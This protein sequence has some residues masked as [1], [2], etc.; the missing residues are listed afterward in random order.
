MSKIVIAILHLILFSVISLSS[1]LANYT[2]QDAMLDLQKIN[3]KEDSI[4]II[5]KI[6]SLYDEEES[7]D[8]R[9]NIAYFLSLDPEFKTKR[10]QNYYLKV[11]LRGK[12]GLIDKERFRLLR[13]LADLEFKKGKLESA[14]N[15][16]NLALEIEGENKLDDYLNLQKFWVLVNLD[17]NDEALGSLGD[18]ILKEKTQM[19]EILVQDYA[20]VWSESL[21]KK[22][23]QNIK[24][25][26]SKE[27]WMKYRSSLLSGLFSGY[28]REMARGKS[29]ER[30]SKALVQSDM[31]DDFFNFGF[32]E[33]KFPGDEHCEFLNWKLPK[34]IDRELYEKMLSF[35]SYCLT[36]HRKQVVDLYKHIKTKNKPSLE[37][38]LI[39][40]KVDIVKG[41]DTY[42]ELIEK[43]IKYDL[44]LKNYILSCIGSPY[45]QSV[46]SKVLTLRER[47]F[48]IAVLNSGHFSQALSTSHVNEE[49]K[50]N[51]FLSLLLVTYFFDKKDREKTRFLQL[52]E[53]NKEKIMS[54]KHRFI[55][56]YFLHLSYL[57]KMPKVK[58]LAELEVVFSLLKQREKLNIL[59]VIIPYMSQKM[60]VQD[61]F[62]KLLRQDTS[63]INEP[64]VYNILI[65]DHKLLK[66]L[67]LTDEIVD[68]T[69]KFFCGQ[70][71]YFSYRD[72]KTSQKKLSKESLG[73]LYIF[74]ALFTIRNLTVKLNTLRRQD[75]FFFKLE[76]L[77]KKLTRV[78]WQSEDLRSSAFML[79]SDILNKSITNIKKHKTKIS[80]KLVEVLSNY[81][82][83]AS[84]VKK[85]SGL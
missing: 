23:K 80:V 85:V 60:E 17:R 11:A 21:L 31:Y 15:N 48:S 8:A 72:Y 34:K 14:L 20:K 24:I 53:R 62:L 68:K 76:D 36:S 28:V 16:Y 39:G 51:D 38:A 12:K 1:V 61:Y 52:Y 30:L 27:Q 13:T 59:K 10:S 29:K 75:H 2:L 77:N 50:D 81:L 40:E 25:F 18:F 5:S 26:S 56:P 63:L 55:Y 32:K 7:K 47:E 43:D 78:K 9:A 49:V 54:N 6:E 58:D 57:E 67:A 4:Q 37:L 64:L 33:A 46:L 82:M 44:A 45:D 74:R 41:C 3:K 65:K 70:K 84:T 73:N 69:L 83:K 22:N 19:H 66:R 35:S 71:K 79:Y 42:S